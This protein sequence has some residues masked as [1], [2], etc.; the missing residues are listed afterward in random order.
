MDLTYIVMSNIRP[1]NT[2]K[3]RKLGIVECEKKLIFGIC[4]GDF[5]ASLPMQNMVE[6]L[7]RIVTLFTQDLREHPKFLI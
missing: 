7:V 3:L 1:Y 4:L 6:G 2:I 5:K